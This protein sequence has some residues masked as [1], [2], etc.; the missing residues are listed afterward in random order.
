MLGVDA[1]EDPSCLDVLSWT[2]PQ[3]RSVSGRPHSA[4]LF[5]GIRVRTCF[6]AARDTEPR[7]MKSK[8]YTKPYRLNEK[9]RQPGSWL[10]LEAGRGRDCIASRSHLNGGKVGSFRA[11]PTHNVSLNSYGS[12]Q[13]AVAV[14]ALEE[15]PSTG[16][17]TWYGYSARM[18]G[19]SPTG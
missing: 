4:G 8:L 12:I 1:R 11:C 9:D 7:T 18:T 17:R 14:G 13:Q 15:S 6:R 5:M 10:D 3:G 19:L 2:C 16:Q